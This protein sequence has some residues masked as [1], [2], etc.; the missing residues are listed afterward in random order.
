MC[1]LDGFSSFNIFLNLSE[2]IW[3]ERD[4]EIKWW[5]RGTKNLHWNRTAGNF[6]ESS[7]SF[8]TLKFNVVENVRSGICER[9]VVVAKKNYFIFPEAI[10]QNCAKN[11]QFPSIFNLFLLSGFKKGQILLCSGQTRLIY[12]ESIDFL[13]KRAYNGGELFHRAREMKLRVS[14]LP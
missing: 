7:K 5:W 10:E 6:F 2:N 4:E 3:I 9:V 14:P 12:S 13:Q 8:L 11:I 1:N